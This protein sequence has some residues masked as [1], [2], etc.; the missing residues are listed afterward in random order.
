MIFVILLLY[1]TYLFGF[2]YISFNHFTT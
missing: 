1:V 2:Y